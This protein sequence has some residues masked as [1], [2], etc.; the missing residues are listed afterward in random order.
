MPAL[1]P[2]YASLLS[3]PTGLLWVQLSPSGAKQVDLV[4]MQ[5]DGRLVARIR[6]PRPLTLYEIGR[7][8]IL[9]SYTDDADELHVAAYKLNR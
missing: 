6:L 1:L 8:Y 3:D 4:A 2:P 9:G 7:D 5:L